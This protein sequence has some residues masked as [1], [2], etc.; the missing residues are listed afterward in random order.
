MGVL[1]I[2]EVPELNFKFIATPLLAIEINKKKHY[3]NSVFYMIYW[4]STESPLF[5]II[6]TPASSLSAKAKGSA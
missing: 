6:A 1:K 5:R 3:E 4:E 2:L